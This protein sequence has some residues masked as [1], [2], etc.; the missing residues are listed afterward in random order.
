MTATEQQGPGANTQS[1]L[2]LLKFQERFRDSLLKGENLKPIEEVGKVILQI[3]LKGCLA[4]GG[5]FLDL[6]LCP[7]THQEL[8][9]P[10]IGQ[11]MKIVCFLV[12]EGLLQSLR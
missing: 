10:S 5:C 4:S 1:R 7:L 8:L 11:E 2:D 9:N 3:F 12:L 6:S